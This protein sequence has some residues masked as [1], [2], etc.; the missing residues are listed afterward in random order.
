MIVDI[1]KYL[2][3]QYK[4]KD[5]YMNKSL[6]ALYFRLM[7]NGLYSRFEW[8]VL[9]DDLKGKSWFIEKNLSEHGIM[10]FAKDPETGHFMMLPALPIGGITMYEESPKY[11]LVAANGKTFMFNREDIAIC[12]DNLSRMPLT[13]PMA[14]EY[15]RRVADIQRTADVRLN[16]HKKPIIWKG[17]RKLIESLKQ[18]LRDL[19]S[20]EETLVFD[21]EDQITANKLE[22]F[23]SEIKFLNRDLVSY[24]QDLFGEFY[25]FCGVN[26][27]PANGKKERLVS[28]EQHSNDEQV[29]LFRQ[30][31]L[32]QRQDFCEEVK[33]K[34]GVDIHVRY[35]EGGDY[36]V[37]ET[38]EES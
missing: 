31:F 29:L 11:N 37:I 27:N 36:N 30:S 7:L 23:N 15:S 34:F 18:A 38:T 17:P 16:Q 20:N 9:P 24:K 19:L 14:S 21:D 6:R 3:K 4:S 1:T 22:M 13:R 2:K 33:E 35:I 26:F 25:G 8:D 5:D 12:Y 28:E 10:A 32:K